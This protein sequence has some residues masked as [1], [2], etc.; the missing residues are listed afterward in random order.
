MTLERRCYDVILPSW[1][2]N[3]CNN[4]QTTSF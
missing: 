3:N 1:R 2:C 4:V